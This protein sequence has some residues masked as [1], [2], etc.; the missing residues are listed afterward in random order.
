M[1]NKATRSK[2][3]AGK[4]AKIKKKKNKNKKLGLAKFVLPMT[5]P[6]KK[7]TSKN[8]PKLEEPEPQKKTKTNPTPGIFNKNLGLIDRCKQQMSSSLLRLIDETLYT[9]DV[10]DIPLDR[11]KFIAY[12]DAYSEVCKKWPTQPIDY[13]VKFI[14]KRMF[15]KRPVHKFRFAD[16]GC[17]REPLLKSKLPPKANVQ[18][19]DLVSVHKDV[20]EANM[21]H[22]PVDDNSF[23]CA[24]YCL[25][26][27]AKNLGSVIVEAK[28]ILKLKGSLLIVEVTS[29][30]ESRE[31]RFTN[32]LERLGFKLNSST[33]LKPNAYFTFFHFTKVNNDLDYSDSAKYVELK[34]C[35]YKAR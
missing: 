10:S 8:E 19:F 12:H 33:P 20:T 18:S 31:R 28:R 4:D 21:E 32:R 7:P 6:K 13:I 16:V 3:N 30:F 27:M 26:L 9:S 14:K 1:Q 24:V 23:D 25:S 2:A 29:R 11:D 5:K 35:I 22:L 17:G 15:P 34:P